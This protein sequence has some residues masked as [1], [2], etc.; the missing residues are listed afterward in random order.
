MNEARIDYLVIGH[1]TCDL[2]PTGCAP[3]GTVA[4]AGRTAQVLGC[5]TAVVTSTGPGRNL[6]QALP[7]IAVHNNPAEQSTTFENIYQGVDH[8]RTQLVHGLANPL[9][10]ADVPGAWQRASIVHLGPIAA[11]IDPDVI[12]LFTNSLIGL[13][14]QGWLRRWDENGR[15]YARHWHAAAHSLPLA[16]AVILSEEDLLDDAMLDQYRQWSRLLV[17]TQGLHGCTVFMGTETRQVPAPKVTAREFTGAGDIFAAAFLIRLWQTGGNPW[18][19]ARFANLIAS[20]SVTQPDI[21]HKMSHLAQ[22][23]P[24]RQR[25]T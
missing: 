10:P 2:T 3:G 5:R 8:T 17:L 20:Q 25:G 11:E 24:D 13:T 7:H 21:D 9:T 4:Y 23:W 12:H 19:A 1:L 16:A 18:E 6:A 14:P 15:V 22:V